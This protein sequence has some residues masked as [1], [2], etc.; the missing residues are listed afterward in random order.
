MHTQCVQDR[1]LGT[2][3]STAEYSYISRQ[4]RVVNKIKNVG[5]VV[6]LNM[7][8]GLSPQLQC[9]AVQ[10]IVAAAFIRFKQ[11]RRQMGF[12]GSNSIITGAV[13]ASGPANRK[14][15]PVSDDGGGGGPAG[16]G[17]SPTKPSLRSIV[18][19]ELGT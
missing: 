2:Y 17:P 4:G 16:P 10:C 5:A 13:Q 6:K 12:L 11:Q 1:C 3:V 9:S 7:S 15:Q 19:I 14:A 8:V 18:K